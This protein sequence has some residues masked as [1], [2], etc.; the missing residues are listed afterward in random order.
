M[1]QNDTIELVCVTDANYA[2]HLAVLLKSIEA[3]KGAEHVRVHA[4]LD[5]VDAA[6]LG[7]IRRSVPGLN[8]IYYHVAEHPALDLPPLLQISRATY[9]RLIMTEVLPDDIARVLYL[10][11]DMI[12]TCSLIALW[13]SELQGHTCGAIEDPGVDPAVFARIYKL[14]GEGRYFNAGML[15]I[16]MKA[17]R[18]NGFLTQALNQLIVKPGM[19]E[20]ADQDALNERLWQDWLPLDP[21]WNYQREHLYKPDRYSTTNPKNK[22]PA[23]LHFTE[24]F[25]P[26]QSDEWHP[27]AWL[28]WKHLRHTPFF[29]EIRQRDGISLPRLAKF[30]LK[31]R[32]ALMRSRLTA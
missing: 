31:Y 30:W 16:D 3:N 10:D 4:I 2:P 22:L 19:Y 11:I 15:L 5:G 9:L 18:K 8:I 32:L 29:A 25:K 24:R 13:Q 28:Y 27:Y 17:A 12:V 20:F 7:Q 26:W 23:V 14:K 21:K 1:L 6:L